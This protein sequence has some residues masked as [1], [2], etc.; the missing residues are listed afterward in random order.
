VQFHWDRQGKYDADSSCWVRV[1]QPWAGKRWGASFWPRIGQ[2]VV[3]SFLEGD[4]DQPLIT[5]SVYNADQ[6]P[7]YLGKGPDSKHTNDNKLSGVKSNTTTGG[8]GFN[9]WRFDD[10]KDKEQVF[11]HA[12]RDMDARVKHDSR[13]LVLRDRHLIVGD[14]SK[15]EGDQRELV[16]R[17]KHLNVKRHHVEKIEGDMTLL[18]GGGD[19]GNQDVVVKKDKKEL[20][21]GDAHHHVK[22]AR[23]EKVDGT[24]SLTVGMN[25]Q[26]KVG[27]NHA[28]EAGIQVHIKAGA[29]LILEAGAQLTLLVGGNFVDINPGGVFIQGTMVMI[30]SGGA[31]GAGSGASPTSPQDAKEAKPTKPDEADNAKTGQKSAPS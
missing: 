30:N 5:G 29:T 21:E 10:T 28:L 27:M 20:V 17:D 11:L 25:Q 12:E 7:P 31:P 26:E 16:Y 19:G 1:A 23:N 8:A 6:M 24:Q 3:V 4:P 2:E 13:E 18:V 14:E 15:K 22:G 9:E